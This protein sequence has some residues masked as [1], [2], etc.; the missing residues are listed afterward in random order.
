MSWP[1]HRDS[2]DD[3]M[4]IESTAMFISDDDILAFSDR[5]A[6]IS[7]AVRKQAATS[8]T[9][10]LLCRPQDSFLQVLI[11]CNNYS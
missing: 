6:D 5:C 10:L 9:D 7:V 8:L 1:S 11:I 4:E 2:E 3:G